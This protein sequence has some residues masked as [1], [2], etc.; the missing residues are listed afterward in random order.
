MRVEVMLGPGLTI[1][2]LATEESAR[3]WNTQ[4]GVTRPPLWGV[5]QARNPRDGSDV[6]DR[7]DLRCMSE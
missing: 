2:G 6:R 4:V 3:P 7:S 5:G 1:S